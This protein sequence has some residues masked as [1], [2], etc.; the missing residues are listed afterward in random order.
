MMRVT[1]GWLS[2]QPD[3]VRRLEFVGPQNV[4][5]AIVAAL[6]KETVPPKTGIGG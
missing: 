1:D 4:Q 3:V 6:D 2:P 5:E